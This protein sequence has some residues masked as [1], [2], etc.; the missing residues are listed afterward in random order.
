MGYLE[1]FLKEV[2][3]GL[4]LAFGKSALDKLFQLR[5]EG[6]VPDYDNN[7]ILPEELLA[8]YHKEVPSR[9]CR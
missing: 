1:R 8:Q 7:S 5:N 9:R 4:N 3:E 2:I 6:Y